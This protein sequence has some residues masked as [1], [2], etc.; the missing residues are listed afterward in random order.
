MMVLLSHFCR[1]LMGDWRW[2][3][4][5]VPSKIIF[6]RI[7]AGWGYI[8][9]AEPLEKGLRVCAFREDSD[10]PVYLVNQTKVFELCS[11]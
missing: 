6:I 7:S 8:I 1:Y 11:L 10:Q 4:H 5:L 3:T 2:Y 9:R